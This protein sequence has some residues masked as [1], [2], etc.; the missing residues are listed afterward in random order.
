MAYV[1]LV[2]YV[3][4]FL[5]AQAHLMDGIVVQHVTGHKGFTGHQ[6]CS[7]GNVLRRASHPDVAL[8]GIRAE[9]PQSFVLGLAVAIFGRLEVSA[10]ASHFPVRGLDTA[11]GHYRGAFPVVNTFFGYHWC[12]CRCRGLLIL[13]GLAECGQCRRTDSKKHY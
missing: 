9:M 1:M 2:L 13:V 6:G 10:E 3:T 5:I 7:F 12:P 4:E 11:R 8:H